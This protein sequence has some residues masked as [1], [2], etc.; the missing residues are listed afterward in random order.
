MTAMEMLIQSRRFPMKLKFRPV[1]MIWSIEMLLSF[2]KCSAQE[3]SVRVTTIAENTD[4]ITPTV[5]V[6]ANPLIGPVAR[7]KR[8]A[9]VISVV[10]LAS[11]ITV[12]ALS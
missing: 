2:S 8:I 5:S 10:A 9:A 6:T 3:N 12:N 11:K 7:K 4:A 1:G